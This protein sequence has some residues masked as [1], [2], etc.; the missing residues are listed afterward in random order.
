M[1]VTR[2]FLMAGCPI[3]EIEEEDWVQAL[4]VVREAGHVGWVAHNSNPPFKKC[5]IAVRFAEE[6]HVVVPTEE[7]VKALHTLLRLS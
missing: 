6:G 1:T 2:V 5:R 4:A 7:R 3:F